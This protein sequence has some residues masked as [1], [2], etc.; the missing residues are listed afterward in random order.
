MT[1]EWDGDRWGATQEG[2]RRRLEGQLPQ[3]GRMRGQGCPRGAARGTPLG[4]PSL[5]RLGKG[6]RGGGLGSPV[7]A[8]G[9]SLGD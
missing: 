6:V 3:G 8:R 4:R 2:T 7:R 5:G 9:Q 1:E